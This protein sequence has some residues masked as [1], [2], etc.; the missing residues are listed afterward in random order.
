MSTLAKIQHGRTPKPPRLLVYG[1]PGIGKSTFG[2]QAPKPIFVPTEDGL[3]EIDCAKFP[4]A[5]NYEDVMAA[6]VELRTQPHDYET[7]VLDS[8]DWLE[9]LVWDRVCT[10]FSVKNI[11]KADGGYARGYTHAVTYWR[12]IVEQLNLL[13]HQR[14]M[15]VVMI[16]HAKVEKFEDPEAPPYDRYSP[17]LHKHASA[18]ITEWCDAVLFAT[19]KFRTS[20][21]DAGFGRKRS[22]AHAIGKDGGERILRTV[23][24]PSCVAKN[25]YGL[26]EELPLSW[27]AFV[28]ALSHQPQPQGA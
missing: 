5:A 8:L 24:G 12:E 25:R 3:D 17:R 19:R 9:R 13:R 22:I 6:L 23:G 21:D 20:S 15:V 1:T 10:D 27:D 18:L 26:T 2:S 28:N 7:V 16:A 4:L 11:E 14:G